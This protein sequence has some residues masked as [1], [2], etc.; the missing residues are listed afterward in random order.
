MGGSI[1]PDSEAELDKL[2]PAVTAIEPQNGSTGHTCL[3]DGASGAEEE[4]DLLQDAI[5]GRVTYPDGTL[6]AEATVPVWLGS[7]A[8]QPMSREE[9]AR[10]PA[11]LLSRE[12]RTRCIPMSE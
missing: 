8:A 5:R 4:V 9:A 10:A 7:W 3:T 6:A 12:V 2:V 1:L 11:M